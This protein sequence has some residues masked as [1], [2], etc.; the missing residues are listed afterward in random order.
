MERMWNRRKENTRAALLSLASP[1]RWR[2]AT[3]NRLRPRFAYV[4]FVA[5]DFSTRACGHRDHPATVNLHR[6]TDNLGLVLR[7]RLMKFSWRDKCTIN[8]VIHA[9]FEDDNG[10]SIM[11]IATQMPELQMK[12]NHARIRLD[13]FFPRFQP[14]H[15]VLRLICINVH[16][17][18][19]GSETARK[20]VGAFSIYDAQ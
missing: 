8:D 15:F 10:P 7:G 12:K 18:F 5:T 17:Q 14:C 6:G 20:Q 11:D 4:R 3:Y 19:S 1:G 16:C 9:P 2:S 13:L